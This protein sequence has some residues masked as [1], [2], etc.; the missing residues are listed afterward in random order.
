ML[1]RQKRSLHFR[2]RG[3]RSVPT[4]EHTAQ[5]Q[6]HDEHSADKSDKACAQC[7]LLNSAAMSRLHNMVLLITTGKFSRE[8]SG[9]LLA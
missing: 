7:H 3:L 4:R 6:A 9:I 8:Y 1:A 2:T 5:E